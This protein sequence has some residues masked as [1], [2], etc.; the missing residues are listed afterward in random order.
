LIT[1]Q[2]E[3]YRGLA[4]SKGISIGKPFVYKTEIPK[5]DFNSS[6]KVVVKNEIDNYTEAV[7]QSKRELKKIFNLAKEKLDEKNLLI[8]EAQLSFLHDDIFHK[9]I[10]ERVRLEKKAAYILFNNEIKLIEEKLISSQ[11]D[12]IKEKVNDLE[13]IKSR[14]LRNMLKGK[15]ISKIEENCIVV[16]KNLT[17]SDT[18]LFSNRKLLGFATNLGGTNSHVAIIARS[19]NLP[20]VVGM[21]DITSHISSA[22]YLIVD[23]YKGLVIKNPSKETVAL[24]KEQIKKNNSFEQSLQEIEKLPTKT[25]DGV[26]I[27]LNVNLEFNKELDYVITHTGCGVGLYRTEHIFLAAGDFPSEEAQNK[28]YKMVAE[29]L[30]PHNVTIRTFDIG[31][32]KLL[33][34]SDKE[35]NPFLGWRGIRICL[36][37][38]EKFLVQLRAILRASKKGNVKIMFPMISGVEEVLKTKELLSKA[39]DDLRRKGVPFDEKIQ[40][41]I[42]VEVPSA[43]Y[44]ADALAKEVDFFSVGTNDLIQYLLAADRGSS[45]VAG[46][47]QKFHP[48]VI[49]A[50]TEIV[51]SAN[52]NNIGLSVC[53]E[54]A[55]DPLG[56]LLLMGL[57]ITDLSVEVSSFLRIKK[58][59]RSVNHADVKKVAAQVVKMDEEKKINEYLMNYYNELLND[60][61]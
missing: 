52:K 4:A 59:I 24:Y 3:T 15:L 57:G 28:Q 58:L 37:K 16:A 11:D 48:A 41:G 19:L 50:L 25:K 14:V 8:F 55:G 10:I 34:E 44:V 36:D 46:I 13:D 31:G 27:E 32:D 54:M 21:A 26:K 60:K 40:I 53:G 39:K 18:I 51:K 22:D 20:A 61:Q 45:L 5:F 17:P 42:M 56:T 30:Y 49:K 43:V 12:Y 9:K 2:E 6:V 35:A 33:P 1:L 7:E 38:P 29:R 47:Y 23:G